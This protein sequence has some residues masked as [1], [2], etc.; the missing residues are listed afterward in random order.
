MKTLPYISQA[1]QGTNASWK[2]RP[3]KIIAR[4]YESFYPL[5][6]GI[7]PPDRRMTDLMDTQVPPFTGDISAANGGYDEFGQVTIEQ[8][9]PLKL[10]VTALLGDM[11]QSSV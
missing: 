2:K 3:N 11:G 7:R 1:N 10:T 5:I 4:V 6:N 9:L 8:D